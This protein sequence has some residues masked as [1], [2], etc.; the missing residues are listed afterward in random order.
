MKKLIP[1]IFLL[2]ILGLAA[3]RQYPHIRFLL[4]EAETLMPDRPGSSLILLESVRFPEKLSSEDYAT[5]CL[6]VTQARDKNHVEHTSD[7]LIDVA[8]RYFEKHGLKHKYGKA[9]YYKGRV[10]QDLRKRKE[11]LMLYLKARDE[12]EELKDYNLLFLI[13]SHLGTLYGYQDMKKEALSAY[14]E[15]YKYAVLDKDSSS[16]SYS[17]SY[18]GRIYGLYKKWD[19]S[20]ANYKQAVR[21]AESIRDSS[22]LWLAMKELSSVYI[23]DRNFNEA[24]TCLSKIDGNWKNRIV[25][26][27]GRFYL[28]IGN[29]YRLKED[30]DN[31]IT[32]LNKALETSNVYT[33]REIYLCF[34]YLYEATGDYKKAIGYNNLYKECTDSIQIAE[35]QKNIHEI[36]TKYENEKLMNI[37][38]ELRWKQMQRV[39]VGILV[40]MGLIFTVIYLSHILK[41]RKDEICLYQDRLDHNRLLI[42]EY[43]GKITDLTLQMG[44]NEEELKQLRVD[45]V[46]NRDLIESKE[47]AYRQLSAEKQNLLQALERLNEKYHYFLLADLRTKPYAL[48]NE[49]WKELFIEIDIIY[50]DFIK[51]LRSEHPGLTFDDIKYCCLFKLSFSMAEIAIMMNVQSSSVS[52]R[53]LRIKKHFRENENFNLDAYIH[54]F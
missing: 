6:L 45:S 29:L 36:A 41:Q 8:V 51:R 47:K 40:L 34:Y 20:I 28:T 25:K 50:V 22:A 39:W 18:I 31:A 14:Q 5:W 7:S 37:N 19:S 15:S 27:I 11:A 52:R 24:S 4:Q 49:D 48:A 46:K 35:Y 43:E 38:N 17:L 1:Y 3:C 33:R 9:L 42:Q 21:I 26:D 10:C 23:R 53:K 16:I 2:L 32:Y 44:M 54:Q 13:C 12:V 30:N